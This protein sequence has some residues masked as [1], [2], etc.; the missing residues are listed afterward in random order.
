M[1]LT[2]AQK[3]EL[4]RLF[5]QFD[6]DGSGILTKK[7]F[8]INAENAAALG[9]Y[10]PGSTE[11]DAL[12]SQLLTQW[13][14]LRAS[15]DTN[16]DGQVTFEEYENWTEKVLLTQPEEFEKV[17]REANRRVFDVLDTDNSGTISFEEF[18]KIDWGTDEA[19]AKE[20][21]DELDVNGNG[22]ITREEFS[23]MADWF[24]SKLG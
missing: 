22:S 1:P 4:K 16:D 7:D 3:T 12:H 23:S 9:G 19:K 14:S 10:K 24:I 2:Q 15:A 6:T 11:Y 21:F 13:D 5:S 20:F 18:K 8:E 17:A